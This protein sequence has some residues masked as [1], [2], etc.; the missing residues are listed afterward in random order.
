MNKVYSCVYYNSQY[1][2]SRT[3]GNSPSNDSTFWIQLDIWGAAILAI[4]SG[5]FRP[6]RKG[7]VGEDPFFVVDSKLFVVHNAE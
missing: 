4:R 3:S 7:T 6:P 5:S 2:D 1:E